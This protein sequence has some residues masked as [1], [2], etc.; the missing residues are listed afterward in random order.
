M[1]ATNLYFDTIYYLTNDIVSYI[2]YYP[3]KCRKNRK[4]V[5]QN[6]EP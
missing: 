3:E 5:G 2:G 6:Q 1:Q 4:N